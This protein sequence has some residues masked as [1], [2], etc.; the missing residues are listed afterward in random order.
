M[1]PNSNTSSFEM[2]CEDFEM[3]GLDPLRDPSLD[4]ATRMRAAQHARRCSRCS[5]L[6]ASWDVAQTELSAFAD[7]T[8]DASALA[9]IEN[10]L[11]QQF[12]MKHQGRRERRNLRLATWALAAAAVMVI[13]LSVW[14][15][16]N[17]Q[18]AK[19][20]KS[21]VAVAT[22]ASTVGSVATN[23]AITVQPDA[24]DN[25]LMASNTT[26][27][28]EFTQLPGSSAQDLDDTSILS[29]GMQRSSL[30]ALGIPVNEER[31]DEW[32][33]VDVLVGSDGS[34]QAV[35]LPSSSEV[36]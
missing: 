13:S 2:R 21:P 32:I 6:A 15:W 18:L 9:I 8:R 23:A 25:T 29:V 3:T 7:S 28:S 26:D 14:G 11:L 10:R 35:R 4:D 36:N 20:G 34:P 19:A 30:A 16:H 1:M 27:S 17:W 22:N 33:Q 12:R 24:A 5:S 31:A